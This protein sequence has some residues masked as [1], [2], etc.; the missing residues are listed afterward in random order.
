MLDIIIVHPLVLLLL[1]LFI[2][3]SLFLKQEKRSYLLPHFST[4]MKN[5][6]EKKRLDVWL[7][8]VMIVTA[9]IALA[10]PSIMKEVETI[11]PNSRDIVLAI[12]TSGSMGITGFSMQEEIQSRL[13]VVKEVL[14]DFIDKRPQDRIGLVVFGD[15]S[16]I[17][18]PLSFDSTS[19]KETLQSLHVGMLGKS[20]AIID[21]LVQAQTL[22][23]HSKSKSKIIILLSDG[24]DEMSKV[25]LSFALKLAKKYHIKIYTIL[26]DKSDSDLLQ[27]ISRKS[28]T[29]PYQA[30]S[31]KD[32]LG[33]YHDIEKL[34]KSDLI[35]VTTKVPS[36][37]YMPFL[38]IALFCALGLLWR[39][40]KRGLS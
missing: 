40:Y 13:D 8:W 28:E 33:I 16:S 38:W 9:I 34:E 27:V 15:K 6:K 11:T 3:A 26:I 23:S 1:P 22:L 2:L 10:N 24:E 36:T 17:A 39:G 25:P 32:L 4:M 29:K 37:L 19:Q 7:K 5:P 21:A 31:K 30:M 18:S 12:D 14:V 35:T 20:T